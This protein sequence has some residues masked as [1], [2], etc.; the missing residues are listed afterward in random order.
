[1]LASGAYR[2]MIVGS[3]YLLHDSE[4]LPSQEEVKLVAYA[5]NKG[6]ELLL[7]CDANFHHEV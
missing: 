4:D 7:T 5:N 1:M 6:L 3:V 2:D